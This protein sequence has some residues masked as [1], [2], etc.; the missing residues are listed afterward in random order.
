MKET[1]KIIHIDMDAFFASVE[2]LDNPELQRRPVIVGGDPGGRGVVAA[3]SYEART[4]GIHSAMPCAKA[5]KLCP[6]AVFIRSNMARYKEISGQIM[7]IF[8]EY[9][10]LVEPLSLDEAFL[11]ISRNKKNL[12]S[13]TWLAEMIRKQIH[14]ETGL[15]ASAGVSY[16]KFLAK[17]ASDLNKPDGISVITPE[18]SKAFIRTLPIGKFFGVGK[19]T[20][21]KMARLGIHTGGDL[22]KFEKS[23]LIHHFGKAGGF[24]YD[25]GR[26]IDTRE[27]K[28]S[29]KRHS[30]GTETTFDH[31]IINLDEINT[32]LERLADK[33]EHALK[34]KHRAGFTL[35]LKVRYGDFTTITRSLT[36]PTPFLSR[37]DMLLHLPALLQATEAG[38]Q[39]VRLLGITISK[40]LDSRKSPPY[41]LR[42]PFPPL[43]KR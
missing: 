1:R 6:H 42:L 41:Q 31:D 16:N 29:R 32:T 14:Q 43:D 35:T 38:R 2:Q 24:F 23:L 21:K 19:V 36:R 33:V 39:K 4:F 26:G 8:H 40:L 10:D 15:T 7:T 18:E 13:A 20:R 9:T 11:D 27:V 30:I 37:E 25:I 34:K 28:T 3:C 17:I 22:L 5:V 12:S